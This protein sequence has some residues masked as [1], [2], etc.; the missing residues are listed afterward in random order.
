VSLDLVEGHFAFFSEAAG[1]A[2]G[3]AP[4]SIVSF[5][6]LIDR[7]LVGGD[8]AHFE[9]ATPVAFRA[10]SGSG[11]VGAPKVDQT[12]VHHDGLQVHARAHAHFDAAGNELGLRIEA[13][14][15]SARWSRRMQ[16]PKLEPPLRELAKHLENGSIVRSTAA[17]SARNHARIFDHDVLEVGRRHPDAALRTKHGLHDL[18]VVLAVGKEA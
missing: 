12:G 4:Y 5:L 18:I 13:S 15:E 14:T 8:D 3:A 11:P 6:D 2:F 16:D 1:G 10:E 17:A 9:V 7:L